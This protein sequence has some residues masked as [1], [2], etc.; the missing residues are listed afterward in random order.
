M[1]AMQLRL[2]SWS[3]GC[4]YGTSEQHDYNSDVLSENIYESLFTLLGSHV[5]Q[6]TSVG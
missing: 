6:H 2:M 3:N 1:V 4:R 5:L